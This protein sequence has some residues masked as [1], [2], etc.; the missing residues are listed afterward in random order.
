MSAENSRCAPFTCEFTS[1]VPDI[2][3]ELDC[4]LVISTNQ[5]DKL[6]FISPSGDDGLVQLAR[7]FTRA[8]GVAAAGDRL[9]VATES[10]VVVLRNAPDLAPLYPAKPNTYDAFYVP[11]ACYF[12]GPV[13]LH[14]L[15]FAAEGLW[16]VNTV[17][18]CLC[19]VDETASF[20]SQWLPPFV[21]K[22]C[23]E[24]RCHLNG[25]AMV[26]GAPGWATALGATDTPKGWRNDRLG[27]GVVIHVPSAEVAIC[28]LAMPHSPR[29][30]DN[31]L[32]LLSAAEGKL[33]RADPERGSFE[34]IVQLPGFARGLA[35][36][37]DYLFAGISRL[38]KRHL[39]GDLPIARQEP[40]CGVVLIH[41]PSGRIAGSL[42]YLASCEEIYDVQVLPGIHRPGIISIEHDLRPGAIWTTEQAHWASRQAP[43]T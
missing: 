12:T 28:G 41:L 22:L 43:L 40:F 9:A 31:Q 34:D 3:R 11:R 4:S 2:L 27:G 23:P 10:E 30:F 38:R 13:D 20:N 6:I 15:A 19:L 39:F 37:G 33:L 21:S 17:F 5:A 1:E 7:N 8:M 36:H 16:A 29:L 42:R 35:R 24:D 26:D 14:D 32:F 18:S 25:M